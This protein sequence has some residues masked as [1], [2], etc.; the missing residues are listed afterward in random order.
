MVDIRLLIAD[1]D[2]TVRKLIKGYAQTEGYAV[3]EAENGISA[4]KMFRRNEYALVILDT[5]LPELDGINVCRQIRKVSDLPILAESYKNAEADRLA[6]F[7]AGVDDYIAKP[8]SP[9]ELMA[10]VKVFLHRSGAIEHR[11]AAKIAFGGL[12]IDMASHKVYVDDQPVTLTPK[13]YDLLVFLAQNPNRAFSR[14]ELLNKVWGYDFFGTDRT[15]DTHIKTLRESIKP[16]QRC[17]ATVWGFGY[18]FEV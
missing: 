1:G 18:K 3:D 4:F 2:D 8:F 17:I 14:D 10:R 13:E 7:G 16:Y 11:P 9:L 5:E 15:V 12:C 6:A